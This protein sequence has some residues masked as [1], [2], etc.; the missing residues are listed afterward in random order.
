MAIDISIIIPCYNSAAFV[1]AAAE[2]ALAQETKRALEVIFVDDGSVDE[3]RDVIAR[4][5]AGPQDRCTRLICQPNGGVAAARNRGIVEARGR[6]ILPLDADDLID[7]SMVEQCAAALDADAELAIAYTDRRD[8][9]DVERVWPAGRFE[10]E[11]LK[12]F[13]QIGYCSLFRRAMWQTIGGYRANV[14]GF[15]DWDLWIAAAARGFRAHHIGQ[16]LFAHRTRGDSQMWHILGDYERLHARIVLNNRDVYA[17]AEVAAA[18][19]FLAT[20]EPARFLQAARALFVDRF[21]GAG[22]G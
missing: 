1:R 5:V 8:F 17:A 7:V 6:Y 15:D 18:E 21:L 19:R 11:R 22:A 12:Y 2:S 10:L 4:V 14:S 13:N 16:P 9:G 20:G 3:T